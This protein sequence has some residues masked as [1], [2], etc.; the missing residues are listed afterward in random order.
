MSFFVA[1]SPKSM[2]RLFQPKTR[3]PDCEHPTGQAF[4]PDMSLKEFKGRN[5]GAHNESQPVL[6]SHSFGGMAGNSPAT[7]SSS[8]S[9]QV[10]GQTMKR[11]STP[12]HARHQQSSRGSHGFHVLRKSPKVPKKPRPNRALLMFDSIKNG[13]RQVSST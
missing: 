6:R 2:T 1:E 5:S 13:I 3:P 10:L 8:V 11:T 7:S 9:T 4:I 12:A